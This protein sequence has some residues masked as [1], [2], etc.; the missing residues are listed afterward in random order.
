[1]KH[2]YL[3]PVA[4][5]ATT[6]FLLFQSNASG[7]AAN[8]NRATG[9]PGDGAN[10]CTSCHS[11][12][13]FG[14]V[15]VDFSIQDT[16]GVEVTEYTP[17]EV[18]SISLDID[19]SNGTPAGYGFQMIALA[20]D[21]SPTNSF[22]NPPSGV[23]VSTTAGRQYAEHSSWNVPGEYSIDWTA[24]GAGSGEVTFYVGANAI[25]ANGIN[26]GDNAVIDDFSISEI[27]GDTTDTTGD[28]DEWPEGLTEVDDRSSLRAFPVPAKDVMHLVSDDQM[29]EIQLFDINGR[30]IKEVSSE[31][32][33]IQVAD[34]PSGLYF[35]QQGEQRTKLI[36]N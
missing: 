34:L 17:G 3:L 26:S 30:L 2:R 25:N 14:P 4:L 13:S 31:Q 29:N 32:R 1:M 19:H 10:T 36:K 28:G 9:A 16:G 21:D 22:V 27:A 8:G 6:A 35:L 33:T 23:Q 24:P 7:P 12:G 15:T 18:Y 20:E 5:V 11:G